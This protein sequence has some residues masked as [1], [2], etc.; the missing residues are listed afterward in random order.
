MFRD[1]PLAD[2]AFVRKPDMDFD[3]S[4]GGGIANIEGVPTIPV[5]EMCVM[6]AETGAIILLMAHPPFPALRHG[7]T[8]EGARQFA[9]GVIRAADDVDAKLKAQAD[10]AIQAARKS[11]DA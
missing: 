6:Q 3:V 8:P 5:R 9:Q 4:L 10:A 2:G 7:F 1:T 11:P